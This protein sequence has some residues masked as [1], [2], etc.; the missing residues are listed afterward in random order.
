MMKT[1]QVNYLL[2]ISRLPDRFYAPIYGLK[3]KDVD[4]KNPGVS[5]RSFIAAKCLRNEVAHVPDEMIETINECYEFST[6][7]EILGKIK[8]S[9]DAEAQDILMVMAELPRELHRKIEKFVRPLHELSGATKMTFDTFIMTQDPTKDRA[10]ILTAQG[11]QLK[12][13]MFEFQDAI[14]AVKEVLSTLPAPK[15]AA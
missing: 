9:L 11:T 12:A 10:D 5:L 7:A 8:D 6:N 4:Y 13:I 2:A 1:Y 15:E 3:G 14:N